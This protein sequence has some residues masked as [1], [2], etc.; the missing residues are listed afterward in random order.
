MYDLQD[1][2]ISILYA[3]DNPQDSELT[4]RS[5][6]RHNLTNQVKL[7][8]DGEEALEYLYATGRYENRDKAQLPSLILLDLKMP[9]VDGIEVLRRV[10][11]E[12]F[13]KMLPVVILTSS[14]EEKDIV[15]SYRLGVNS[16]VVKPLDFDKFSEVA[17]EIG[18]Y[19]ILVNQGIGK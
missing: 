6:K 11:S 7:V 10:R 19:W 15:E 17:S 9:K 13:T 5:L 14:A 12:E 18:F 16:Y 3:E 8:R 2:S 1:Q 4:L